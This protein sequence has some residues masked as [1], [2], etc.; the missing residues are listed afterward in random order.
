MTESLNELTLAEAIQIAKR[1]IRAS[2]KKPIASR[3]ASLATTS[4]S[5]SQTSDANQDSKTDPSATATSQVSTPPPASVDWEAVVFPASKDSAKSIGWVPPRRR[6][7]SQSAPII[8]KRGS[9][10][11]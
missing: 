1:C 4:N 8:L 6:K 10:V 2:F 3:L 11:L 7:G 9:I 5:K